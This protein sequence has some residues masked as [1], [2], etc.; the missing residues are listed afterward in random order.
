MGFAPK[1]RSSAVTTVPIRTNNNEVEN[2]FCNCSLSSL[3]SATYFTTPLKIPKEAREV[4]SC[5]KFRSCPI[6][7]IPSSPTKIAKRRWIK[8]ETTSRIP[9]TREFKDVIFKSRLSRI[10]AGIL[11]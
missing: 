4:S 10:K 3:Y 7:E 9:I 8:K 1:K 2:N 5:V 6:F 11:N